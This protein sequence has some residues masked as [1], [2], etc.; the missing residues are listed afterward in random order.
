MS[1]TG[2]SVS[3]VSNGTKLTSAN[4]MTKLVKRIRAMT[5]KLLPVQVS[6]EDLS[7]PTS[8]YITPRVV[9]A[10][11]EAAGDFL[12][13]LPYAL[14]RARQTF[15]TD[16]YY[17]ASDYD[18]NYGRAIACEVLARKIIHK[19]GSDRLA[20]VMSTR[21]RYRKR[22]SKEE[23]SMASAL[24]LAIDQHCTI[25][26]S[27]NEAQQV[28]DLLWKGQLVQETTENNEISYKP[29]SE[30]E[31]SIWRHFDIHRL[32]VPR[33][34]NVFRIVIWAFYLFVYSQAVR[35]PLERAL[36]RESDMDPWE[37]VLYIMAL[38]FSLEEFH[39]IYTTIK[40]FTWRAFGFWTVIS[41]ITDVLLIS[42]FVLRMIGLQTPSDSHNYHLISFQ[43][44]SFVSPFIWMS[45]F[46]RLVELITVFD[47]YK[48]VGTM[49]I[50]VGSMLKEST[51]FF[52]LL[53]LM[54]I[55]F[56]QGLYAIDAADGE[57][58]HEMTV[59]NALVQ[60]LLQA[61][62]FENMGVGLGLYYL[63]NVATTVILLNILV[64][65][66]SSAYQDVIEDAEAEFLTFFAGKTIAL[67][68][69]PDSYVYPPPFSLI[70]LIL[71]T[72]FEFILSEKGY[73][74]LNRYVMTVIFGIPLLLA[75]FWETVI[76]KS[77]KNFIKNWFAPT[78]EGEENNPSVQDPTMEG[79]HSTLT[80]SK[81]PF[82]E[83]VKVFPDANLSAEDVIL[84]EIR[85]LKE[86]I[87]ELSQR[88][89]AKQ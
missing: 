19:F 87:E 37:I 14:I 4:T 80:I 58:G 56:A 17:D 47:G 75:A 52:A 43:V 8:R 65:L 48:Y 60:A 64:S 88:L 24:E 63:W 82:A 27:S 69:A 50:C 29:Y 11:R 46:E 74:K 18:E 68:R 71:V 51:L 23:S 22:D 67:I 20:S 62:D 83:L 54:A 61:P 81:T 53:F 42:A 2:G 10:Y 86:K 21:Y 57:T 40:L 5:L 59:V 15:M 70:E 39:K 38:S 45:T 76:E 72:P 25:F 36:P 31:H 44:L 16:A 77:N 79:E 12:E 66:F 3:Q 73:D 30:V 28:V 35:Q 9:E 6:V 78:E 85:S 41:M 26:L 33:Y 13:A 89:D 7:S 1:E 84:H 49:Q 34:Q 32:A 55:G